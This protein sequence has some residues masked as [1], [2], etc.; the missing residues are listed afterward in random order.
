M[1]TL[2]NFEPL[3]WTLI[4]I[5]ISVLLLMA[6][7][8]G[9]ALPAALLRAVVARFKNLPVG[10]YAAAGAKYSALLVLRYL[11]LLATMLIGKS[12]FPRLVVGSAYALLYTVWLTIVITNAFL[13]FIFVSDI[14]VYHRYAFGFFATFA[15]L[16]AILLPINMYSWGKSINGLYRF[17]M[18]GH[19]TT[20][21]LSSGRYL[22]PFILLIL[23]SVLISGIWFL[24][25]LLGFA[26]VE[27]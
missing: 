22:E 7:G 3:F 13:L 19:T 17:S 6:L 25:A 12:S 27:Q 15:I 10:M 18:A 1:P 9:L 11:Y 16:F 23:W 21:A 5:H 2:A 26:F 20:S 8:L 24:A 4:W 14:F